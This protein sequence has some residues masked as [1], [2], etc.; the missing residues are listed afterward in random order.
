MRTPAGGAP[1]RVVSRMK[2]PSAQSYVS[3]LPR[4]ES[5]NSG[6]ADPPVVVPNSGDTEL[7]PMMALNSA[8]ASRLSSAATSAAAN[9][10][11]TGAGAVLSLQDTAPPM[12]T[13]TRATAT[14]HRRPRMHYY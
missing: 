6:V 9:G 11:N 10:G 1:V 3:V 7:A 2:R 4:M 5:A 14:T 12:A 13:A 8:E